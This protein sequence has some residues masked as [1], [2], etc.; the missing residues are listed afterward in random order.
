MKWRK[1]LNGLNGGGTRK[2]GAAKSVIERTTVLRAFMMVA[3]Y[4]VLFVLLA[5]KKGL[6][7]VRPGDEEVA[8]HDYYADISFE[9]IDL[10]ETLNRQEEEASKVPAVYRIDQE[11]VDT[12]MSQAEA[13]FDK[14]E[15][16]ATQKAFSPKEALDLLVNVDKV[17]LPPET[18]ALLVKLTPAAEQQLIEDTT[19][20]V[21]PADETVPAGTDENVISEPPVEG[22][23]VEKPTEEEMSRPLSDLL[24]FARV[25]DVSL[26]VLKNLLEEGIVNDTI[27]EPL[28]IEIVAEDGS[29]EESRNV[30]ADQI[31]KTLSQKSVR[32]RLDPASIEEEFTDVEEA[33]LLKTSVYNMVIAARPGRAVT[34]VK[35]EELTEQR[36]LVAKASVEPETIVFTPGQII[37]RK[38]STFTKQNR[39]DIDVWL[40]KRKQQTDEKNRFMAF[41]GNG[42]LLLFGMFMLGWFMNRH[43]ASTGDRHTKLV[44]ITLLIIVFGIALAWGFARSGRSGYFVPVASGVILLA[45]LVDTEIALMAALFTCVIVCQLWN[46]DFGIFIALLGGSLAGLYSIRQVRRRSDIMKAGAVVAV[47][48]ALLSVAM[49]LLMN[50]QLQEEAVRQMQNKAG[51]E[52]VNLLSSQLQLEEAIRQIGREAGHAT[53]NGVLVVGIVM[54]ALPFLES[55]FKV[56]TDIRL[57]EFS[58]LDNPLLQRLLTEVPGTYHHSMIIGLL[59][60]NAADAIGA[61]SVL[62]RVGAYYHD[63]GKLMKPGYFSENQ[64]GVNKHDEL[65]PTMSSRIITGHVKEGIRL[66]EQYHL[67]QPIRDIIV[68]HH[69]TNHV[70]FFFQ[71]ARDRNPENSVQEEDFRYPGPRPQSREAAIVMLADSIESTSRSLTNPTPDRIRNVADKIINQRFIDGQFDECDL[72]LHGL[73]TLADVIS[74]SLVKMQHGRVAYP[75]TEAMAA[76]KEKEAETVTAVSN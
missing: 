56:V 45:I 12:V 15:T 47:A 43:F 50:Q 39:Q 69:G 62:A 16:R 29:T 4:V 7:P 6:E 70:S 5:P 74:K 73:H 9:S 32:S 2:N 67:P 46:N 28:G 59:A 72:T 54:A 53:V 55:V 49:N 18:L 71:K 64:E 21:E 52:A 33:E 63:I 51:Q 58:D 65:S 60:Q 76:G 37:V 36:V 10:L 13:L 19:V 30:P 25:K 23:D 38:G 57:L 8:T 68:Q 24:Y 31:E 75:G 11:V 61:N 3:A 40:R 66:A 27:S 14:I 20:V 1:K 42:L 48:G 26:R 41:L 44:M 22:E 35:D 17:E 34:L